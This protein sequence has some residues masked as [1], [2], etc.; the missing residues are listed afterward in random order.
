MARAIL[1]H[2]KDTVATALTPVASGET[3]EVLLD[4]VRYRVPVTQDIPFAHK[5][6]LVPIAAGDFVYKYGLPIGRATQPIALGDHV[7]NHNLV[8]AK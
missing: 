1:L 8:T 5:F 7:H 2:R 3:V 6:A 4:D